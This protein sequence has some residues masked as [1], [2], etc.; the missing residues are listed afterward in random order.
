ME[1]LNASSSGETPRRL[2]LQV[3]CDHLDARS[4][5]GMGRLPASVCLSAVATQALWDLHPPR[6]HVVTMYGRK[7]ETP[8]WQQAYGA[9]YVY[10][11]NVNRALRVPSLLR[12][13][14]DVCQRT[15]DPR[16]NGLL[17]N[18]YDGA[19]KHY[20]GPHRD[21]AGQLIDGSPIVTLSF[22]EERIFRLRPHG[23]GPKRDFLLEHGSVV[24]L[25]YD[26]NL[27]WTHAVPHF[28]RYRG[29]RISVTLR[30]FVPE[31]LWVN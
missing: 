5:L 25:P 23:G 4:R 21:T 16:L 22:G 27:S 18:W 6:F 9:D 24:V 20:M 29:R 15:I 30:A 12:P 28:A 17:V 3:E 8:R 10:S 1:T 11:G 7:L 31:R 2:E 14:L 13:L 26:T 19:Q